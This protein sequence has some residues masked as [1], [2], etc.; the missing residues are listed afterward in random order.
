MDRI[1]P[2]SRGSM[3]T[4]AAEIRTYVVWAVWVAATAG[5]VMLVLALGSNVPYWDDWLYVPVLTGHQPLSLGFLWS[6]HNEHRIPLPR[7]VYLAVFHLSGGDFRAVMLAST[8]ALSGAVALLMRAA[9]RARGSTAWTDAFL[10]LLLLHPAHEGNLL[11]AFDLVFV[12]PVALGLLA[13]ATLVNVEGELTRREVLTIGTAAVLMQLCSA[14]GLVL[15]SAFGCWLLWRSLFAG[16]MAREDAAGR[17]LPAGVGLM[18][19]G[20]A[21]AYFVGYHGNPGHPA[22][23]KHWAL[24]ATGEVL[25]V[26]LG[27][28]APTFGRTAT[29]LLAAL[30]V[31]TAAALV[32]WWWRAPQ[33]RLAAEALLAA[34]A[35]FGGL[36]LVMGWGRSG[37]PV[38]SGRAS[39]YVTLA[40]PV[41]AAVYVAW[42][43]MPF[44]SLAKGVRVALLLVTAILWPRNATLG[45][46][47]A[48]ERHRAGQSLIADLEEDRP[49]QLVAQRHDQD[50]FPDSVLLAER[51]AMLRAKRLGPFDRT[52]AAASYQRL[53][54]FLRA[55]LVR[56]QS[57]TVAAHE[58][59][60]DG[61]SVLIVHSAG[62][63]VFD[64]RPGLTR[65]RGT[66]GVIP[67]SGLAK[68]EPSDPP[69]D[70]TYF[71]VS[72]RSDEGVENELLAALLEPRTRPE[73][74]DSWSFGVDL[75]GT[76]GQLVL[77]TKPGPPGTRSTDFGDWGYWSDI[78]LR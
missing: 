70:G 26:A 12:L 54:P 64:V 19:L 23:V 2:A 38:G 35:V 6:L 39:R 37:F 1:M 20:L 13:L 22:P 56:L 24:R 17:A 50:I 10:P 36:I 76:S 71:T 67:G 69:F 74:R 51:L 47:G 63:A 43:R 75:P 4:G 48:H 8:A 28:A 21:G 59:L 30:I 46:A 11:W 14:P 58:G 44:T 33:Q 61:R 27:P 31:S 18:C 60:V 25:S 73:D 65:A 45:L 34:V 16:R 72:F 77:R 57:G 68:T 53:Y 5:I 3:R 49:L 66:F 55:P 40:A 52:A 62:E 41:V 78:V 32:A 7:L 29:V 42:C 9:A 15:G